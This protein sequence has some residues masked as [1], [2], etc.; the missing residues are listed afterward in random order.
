MIWMVIINFKCCYFSFL[1]EL[2]LSTARHKNNYENDN[3][4]I[5]YS[6]A[7]WGALV[8]SVAD[9]VQKTH[10]SHYAYIHW[11][12]GKIPIGTTKSPEKPSR[13]DKLELVCIYKILF[14]LVLTFLFYLEVLKNIV[15]HQVR[16]DDLDGHH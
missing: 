9:P 14:L 8:L 2:P 6:L 3:E 15:N 1:L 12:N 5:C 7:K 11:C 10:L 13:L 4:N 16:K